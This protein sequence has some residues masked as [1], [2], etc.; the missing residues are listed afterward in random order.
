M[1]LLPPVD[2]PVTGRARIRVLVSDAAVARIAFRLDGE[3]VAEDAEPPFAA[4]IDFGA[5]GGVREVRA[6]AYDGAGRELGE[7]RLTVNEGGGDRKIVIYDIYVKKL[8][9]G[10]VTLGSNKPPKARRKR[11][12]MYVA[13]LRPRGE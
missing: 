9:R 3:P 5:S 4:E 11:V 8:P 10:R 13:F 1:R 12:S 7:D 6:V 2:Q